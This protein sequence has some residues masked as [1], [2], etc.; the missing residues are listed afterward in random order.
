MQDDNL[1]VIG[2]GTCVKIA[3]M[4]KK[5]SNRVNGLQKD[6]L[7]TSIAYVDIVASFQTSYYISGIAPC[8]DSLVILAYIQEEE[9]EVNEFSS[10]MP[11]CK[12][13]FFIINS[14]SFFP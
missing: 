9:E 6:V 13:F 11:S 8:G 7:S 12:V 10:T 2:W 4:R 3:T 1:L 14:S 5:T